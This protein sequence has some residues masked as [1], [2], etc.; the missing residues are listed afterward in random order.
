MDWCEEYQRSI[1]QGYQHQVSSISYKQ[2][3]VDTITCLATTTAS[4]RKALE[5]L[6]EINKL[7]TTE[8][9][10]RNEKLG[11]AFLKII[12][13]TEQLSFLKRGKG[14]AP[15]FLPKLCYFH[16]HEYDCP[17]H[18]GDCDDPKEGHNKHATKEKKMRGCIKKYKAK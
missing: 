11:T 8:L 9:A 13:L 7:L 16:T 10:T 14:K 17:H 5:T 1:C 6:T 3:T 15:S 2:E 18:S 12:K 4:N